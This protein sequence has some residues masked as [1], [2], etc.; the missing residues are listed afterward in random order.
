M[1]I[2]DEHLAT[3]RAMLIGEFDEYGRLLD[4]MDRTNTG[5]GFNVLVAAAFYV[6]VNRRFG[7][8]YTIADIIQFVAGER[9]RV[10]DR[11]FDIDPR[12]AERLMLAVLGNGSAHD[13]DERAK[14]L[15]QIALLTALVDDENLDDAGLGAFMAE[16]RKVADSMAARN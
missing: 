6:A 3:L 10:D 12:V 8:G 2:T 1:A 5:E 16:A 9:V 11:E 15:A 14:G 4:H 13:L 7:Q